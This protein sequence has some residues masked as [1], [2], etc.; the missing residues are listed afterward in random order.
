MDVRIKRWEAKP[1]GVVSAV[2]SK[3][4]AQRI[5]I[6]AFLSGCEYPLDML[7]LSDDLNVMINCLSE[8]KNNE[9]PKL[10]C[11]ES[12]AALRF[13][14]PV[15]MA[16]KN[17][18]EFFGNG[19][20]PQ[21]PIGELID[22]M[23][24]HG[25]KFSAD[26]LPFKVSGRLTGGR[27][28]L[29]GNIS[30]QYIS[31]L[32]MACPLLNGGGEIILTSPLE[33]AAYVDLTIDIMRDFNINADIIG[34]S[35]YVVKSGQ[36]YGIK[37]ANKLSAEKDW[38]S[39]AYFMGMNFMGGNITLNGLNNDSKQPDRAIADILKDFNNVSGYSVANF[40][41]L[42]PLLAVTACSLQRETVLTN[43]GRL[44]FKESDRLETT[45]LMIKSL[46]G[47]A[48]IKD[49]ALIV[50]GRE[51]LK[52]GIVDG[53]GDHRIVMSA[54]AASVIC[55]NDVV[56]LNAEAVTKSYPKFFTD[57]KK[58]GGAADVV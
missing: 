26:T 47:T 48:E 19:K 8:L 28:C 3:S 41:D 45:A 51:K 1:E 14:L 16:V 50:Y 44:R 57:F 34:Q 11:G 2:T 35:G 21:R 33:S 30:S 20:L 49:D 7:D 12:G 40:P 54:A 4:C 27:F 29:P 18:A 31:G 17:G 43:A 5:L 38:S 56:I 32:L 22:E 23:K 36:K 6:C 9:Y 24:N 42:F 13:L 15:A 46:G 37:A 25:C 53:Y 55:E 52:G 10:F 39:A 58:I